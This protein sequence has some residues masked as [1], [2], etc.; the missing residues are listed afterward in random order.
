M[1]IAAANDRYTYFSSIPFPSKRN[2]KAFAALVF[3]ISLWRWCAV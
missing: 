3:F 1:R 2:T